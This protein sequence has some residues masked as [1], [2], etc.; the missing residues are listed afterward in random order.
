MSSEPLQDVIAWI[1]SQPITLSDELTT[2]IPGSGR[3]ST[4]GFL[5]PPFI[6][7]TNS[8]TASPIASTSSSENPLVNF[9]GS[10]DE[11]V[12]EASSELIRQT[13]ETKVSN[14]IDLEMFKY[15]IKPDLTPFAD[16]TK[17]LIPCNRVV[18][19]FLQNAATI[20]R[21]LPNYN[22]D[23]ED[24][25]AVSNISELVKSPANSV[26]ANL[27]PTVIQ[28]TVSHSPHADVVPWP[29]M[30]DRLIICEHPLRCR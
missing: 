29:K 6:A 27:L 30:R 21:A 2:L 26:P 20:K 1:G 18:K 24:D 10:S 9:F 3:I 11:S 12:F 14:Y 16:E 23:W 13:C 15:L 5:G 4:S 7:V 8:E 19:A 25:Y 22:Y 28:I 17:I